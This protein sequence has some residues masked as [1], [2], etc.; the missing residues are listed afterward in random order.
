MTEA[1]EAEMMAMEVFMLI[2]FG[3]DETSEGMEMNES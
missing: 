2:E 1:T 3:V